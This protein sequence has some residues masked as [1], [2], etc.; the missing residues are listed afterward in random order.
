LDK[1]F[2]KRLKSLDEIRPII[3]AVQ[4]K[5]GYKRPS[6]TNLYY[7]GNTMLKY[8]ILNNNTSDNRNM[9]LRD[10]ETQLKAAGVDAEYNS[11]N[12][13]VINNYTSENGARQ[14]K[15]IVGY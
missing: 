9:M 3:K 1:Y 13:I 7:S 8:Y 11:G 15:L 10:M 6:F 5:Y 12:S 4:E 2:K 14:H